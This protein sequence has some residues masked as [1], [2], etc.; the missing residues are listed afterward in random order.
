MKGEEM[1]QI[2]YSVKAEWLKALFSGSDEG[3]K[4][5]VESV[6]QTILQAEMTEPS[7]SPA[8]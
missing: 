7:P 1:T 5:L 4:K 8:L 2:N 6:V 3:L